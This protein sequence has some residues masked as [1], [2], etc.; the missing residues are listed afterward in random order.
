MFTT[1]LR[2]WWFWCFPLSRRV[3]S[4]TRQTQSVFPE[5]KM[6]RICVVNQH[7]QTMLELSRSNFDESSAEL[8]HRVKMLYPG[9]RDERGKL[10]QE[11][12]SSSKET[13]NR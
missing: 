10:K 6:L 8:N 7:C 1:Y 2:T 9:R 13:W 12:T 3:F 4:L 5:T 11:I